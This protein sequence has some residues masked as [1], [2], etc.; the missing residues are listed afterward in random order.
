[1]SAYL[2][3]FLPW[4]AELEE[5]WAGASICAV[6]LICLAVLFSGMDVLFLSDA[7]K[8]PVG[9]ILGSLV[10]RESLVGLLAA[11]A[12]AVGGCAIGILVEK[13][14]EEG[15]VWGSIPALLSFAL[16]SY[17][18]LGLSGINII[19][20]SIKAMPDGIAVALIALALFLATFTGGWMVG[21]KVVEWK[22][23]DS[24]PAISGAV[25]FFFWTIIIFAFGYLARGL[26]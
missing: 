24:L 18:F 8:D 11:L 1:M 15:R 5:L 4:R 26:Q 22:D 23:D 14:T 10:T 3:R 13:Q 7:Q 9:Y 2:K 17:L 20:E 12:S 16:L 6:L 21:A 19:R 25:G